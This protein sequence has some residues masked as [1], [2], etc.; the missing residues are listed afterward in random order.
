[1]LYRPRALARAAKRPTIRALA[2]W[3]GAKGG[4]GAAAARRIGGPS[5]AGGERGGGEKG[6]T[7]E[8]VQQLV[9]RLNR[10]GARAASLL[11]LVHVGF[12]SVA[13]AHG[14]LLAASLCMP[15]PLV[16]MAGCASR[17]PGSPHHARRVHDVRRVLVRAW[18]ADSGSLAMAGSSL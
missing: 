9:D 5:S 15:G 8:K 13:L 11:A 14:D 16:G 2:R 10:C 6:F 18:M 1:M 12:W 7:T 3:Q 17:G 4:G